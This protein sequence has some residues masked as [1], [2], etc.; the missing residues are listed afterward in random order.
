MGERNFLKRYMDA[1][2]HA[3]GQ[4]RLLDSGDCSVAGWIECVDGKRMGL[5]G[6]AW[7]ARLWF[8]TAINAKFAKTERGEQEAIEQMEE[9]LRRCPDGPAIRPHIT[10]Y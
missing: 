1:R 3:E 5:V 8:V 10:R 7:L 9:C 4:A 6:E 2:E